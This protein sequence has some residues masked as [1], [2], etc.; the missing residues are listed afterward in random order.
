MLSSWGLDTIKRLEL[1]LF[2]PGSA[3]APSPLSEAVLRFSKVKNEMG[4]LQYKPERGTL[5]RK[6]AVA[7]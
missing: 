5:S 4:M 7:I 3:G 1:L 6:L 2:G